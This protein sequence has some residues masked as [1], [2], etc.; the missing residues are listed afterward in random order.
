[1]FLVSKMSSNRISIYGLFGFPVGHSLSAP[2]H[3]AGFK[4]Y[5]MSAIYLLF[6]VR[7]ESLKRAV[8]SLRILGIDGVNVTI[9]HKENVIKYL[10][11]VSKDAELIG[12]VNTIVNHSGRLLGYNTDCYGFMK[13]LEEE[14]GFSP[15]SR[16]VFIL[17]AGG[18]ARSV[19][20]ALVEAGARRIIVTDIVDR[21]AIKLVRSLQKKRANCECVAVRAGSRGLY[22]LLLN[23]QLLVNATPCGMK[24][25]DPSPIPKGY[26]HKNLSVFDLVYNRNTNLIQS[27]RRLGLKSTG[28]LGMLLY[29]GAKAF[30]LWTKKKAPVD[31]MRRALKKSLG[32]E[33]G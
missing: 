28:G 17:G 33:R 25:S 29:Q 4:Y 1:M 10:D 32:G 22:E 14:L 30:E 7:P 8:D 3:N 31:I 24:S 23:S 2:M 19:A 12:A 11:W 21:R 20:Y 18:A 16:S 26:L 13:A 27:A 15:M 9:P 6:E 5:R